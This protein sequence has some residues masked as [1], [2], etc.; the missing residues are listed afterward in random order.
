MQVVILNGVNLNMLGVRARA[1]Y[2]CMGAARP[3][4]RRAA[5]PDQG[6]RAMLVTAL[7]HVRYLTGY[8]GSNGALVARP[9]GAVFLTDFRYL[10]RLAPIRE[11]IE[12]QQATQDLLRHVSTR[13]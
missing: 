13:W 8:T 10:Q 4:R 9:D 2:G 1:E 3:S 6:V 5:L 12:A 11:F 7:V